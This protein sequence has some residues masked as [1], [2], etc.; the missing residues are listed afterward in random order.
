MEDFKIELGRIFG[1]LEASKDQLDELKTIVNT[2]FKTV[3]EECNKNIRVHSQTCPF[4]DKLN[5]HIIRQDEYIKYKKE[6]EDKLTENK[7]NK[8]GWFKWIMGIIVSL[9]GIK[10]MWNLIFYSGNKII[11]H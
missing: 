3:V 11:K 2:G 10:E 5:T 8:I 1:K 7:I 9:I 6:N 4:E